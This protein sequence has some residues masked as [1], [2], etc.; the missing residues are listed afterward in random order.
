V[1]LP[2]FYIAAAKA[3][4]FLWRKFLSKKDSQVILAHSTEHK[5][6]DTSEWQK[7]TRLEDNKRTC[8]MIHSIRRRKKCDKG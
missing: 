3:R 1:H 7:I 2:A 8:E 6:T 5:L 4:I